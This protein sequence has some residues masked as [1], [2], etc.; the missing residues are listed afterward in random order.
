M[1]NFII[2]PSLSKQQITYL[3]KLAHTLNPVVLIGQHGLNEAVYKEINLQLGAH[4][5]I[6]IKLPAGEKEERVRALEQICQRCQC[7][8]VGLIG[9]IGIVF[10][11]AKKSRISLPK[12]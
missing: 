6:K 10:K 3:K 2:M 9:R 7:R 5:L 8:R 1:L 12:D 4:E 11:P